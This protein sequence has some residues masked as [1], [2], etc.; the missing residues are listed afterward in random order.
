MK[1]KAKEKAKESKEMES[2]PLKPA[3]VKKVLK[4]FL[5]K[6]TQI[7]DDAVIQFQKS[8][9]EMTRWVAIEAEKFAK[10]R[11]GKRITKDDIRDAVKVHLGGGQ[12]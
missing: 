12:Q 1:E 4:H 2:S 7:E 5:E 8:F 6:E 9:T 10:Y 3:T 11:G